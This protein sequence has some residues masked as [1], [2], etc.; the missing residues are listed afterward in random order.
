[1]AVQVNYK[2]VDNLV[3]VWCEWVKLEWKHKNFTGA[4]ELM[5]RPTA[6][7]PVE[8]KLKVVTDGIQPVQMGLHKSL[9][10]WTFYADL[11]ESLDTELDSGEFWAL[12]GGFAPIAKKIMKRGD[13]VDENIEKIK[14]LDVELSRYKEQ[15]KKTR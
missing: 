8:V 3:G 5:R 2:T 9:T 4:T 12:F 10:L 13:T 6:E 15:I 7:P 1:M 11:E 14:N